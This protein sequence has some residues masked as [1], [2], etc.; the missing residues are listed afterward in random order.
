M[1][2]RGESGLKTGVKNDNIWSK[3]GSAFG[4]PGGTPPTKNSRDTPPPPPPL[5]AKAQGTE[6]LQFYVT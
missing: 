6:E 1:D 4:E 2:F 3:I 5:R